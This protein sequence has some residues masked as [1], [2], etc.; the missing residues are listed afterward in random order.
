MPEIPSIDHHDLGTFGPRLRALRIAPLP[1]HEA[2]RLGPIFAAM[3]PWSLYPYPAA[4][5]ASYLAACETG[6]PRYGVYLDGEIA[7]VLG[8][9]LDWLRGPYVQFLGVLPSFQGQGLGAILLGFVERRAA[10]AGERNIF[11]CASDFNCG[12]IR[13]YERCGFTAV[14]TLD[15]LVRPG[16]AEVLLR[17][18]LREPGGDQK[19]P[20][21]E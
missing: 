8:L 7:G 18:R 11:V 2:L 9:R 5:L 6:A 17:K 20:A 21:G 15:G 3:E 1:A 13:F 10:A 19:G 14:A 16:R 12:A 4:A